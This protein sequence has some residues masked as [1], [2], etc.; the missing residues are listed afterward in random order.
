MQKAKVDVAF[1]P[2]SPFL[3][4]SWTQL[5]NI[6]KHVCVCCSTFVVQTAVLFQRQSVCYPKY[7]W[8]I[9]KY[10]F[11]KLET[12]GPFGSA[13]YFPSDESNEFKSDKLGRV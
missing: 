9:F 11:V 1:N 7:G 8:Q 6:G 13:A 12:N 2:P 10:V 4:L 3:L 5:H